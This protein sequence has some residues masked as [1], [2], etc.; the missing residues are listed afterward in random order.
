ME[1]EYRMEG[2]VR[3]IS[4]RRVRVC[5]PPGTVDNCLLNTDRLR[6]KRRTKGRASQR[7]RFRGERKSKRSEG[8]SCHGPTT[9]SLCWSSAAIVKKRAKRRSPEVC[10]QQQEPRVVEVVPPVPYLP[11]SASPGFFLRS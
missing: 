8:G 11:T 5:V 4:A 9:L 2:D 10:G 7:Q 1:F 6:Y 3:E